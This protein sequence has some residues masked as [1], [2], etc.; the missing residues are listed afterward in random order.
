MKAPG[1]KSKAST[2]RDA[3]RGSPLTREQ[4]RAQVPGMQRNSINRAL[5]DM[6]VSGAVDTDGELFW[7]SPG[8]GSEAGYRDYLREVRRNALRVRDNPAAGTFDRM[9]AEAVDAAIRSWR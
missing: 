9:R 7:L 4:V 1:E 6:C 2:I 5:R 3:L 8:I